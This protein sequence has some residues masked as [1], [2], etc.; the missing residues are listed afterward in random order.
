MMSFFM[1][2][3][4]GGVAVSI[5]HFVIALRHRNTRGALP[6]ALLALSIG[7]YSLG[8]FFEL[9]SSTVDKVFWDNTQFLPTD[10]VATSIFL[11]VIELTVMHVSRWMLVLLALEPLANLFIVWGLPHSYLVR[12]NVQF[13]TIHGESF[14]TYSY[15]PWMWGTIAYLYILLFIATVL[16]G[17]RSLTGGRLERHQARMIFW[18][19]LIPWVGTILTITGNVP[20]IISGLDITPITF[21]ATNIFLALALFRF[22]LLSLVPA[23]R[24]NVL[25]VMD[26]GLIVTSTENFTLLDWNPAAKRLLHPFWHGSW[27]IGVSLIDSFPDLAA[28]KN[29]ATL[30]SDGHSGSEHALFVR[31]T[32]I[33]DD[34]GVSRCKVFIIEDVTEVIQLQHRLEIARNQ[35]EQASITRS[36]FFA[37][38]SHEIR[39]PMGAVISLTDHLAELDLP[40]EANHLLQLLQTQ[41]TALNR[42]LEDI[43]ELSKIE[44]GRIAIKEHRFDLIEILQNLGETFRLIASDRPVK[45]RVDLGAGLPRYV[46]GDQVRLAQVLVNLLTN[47]IK[48]TASGE[49]L[50]HADCSSYE[51]ESGITSPVLVN[52]IVEDSGHGIPEEMLE[53]IFQP[54]E[55]VTEATE[56][57]GGTGLGLAIS[58]QLVELMGGRIYALNRPDKRGARLCFSLLFP[59]AE[60]EV[61]LESRLKISR[62]PSPANL[63]IVDDDPVHRTL[64]E[65][66]L[67][68]SGA[69]CDFAEDGLQAISMFSSVSYDMVLLDIQM[70]RMNGYDVSLNM[71]N[72]E[73]ERSI[74][75]TP[76][77]A[78]TAFSMESE[79]E[80]E[81]LQQAGMDGFLLKPLNREILYNTIMQWA[82]KIPA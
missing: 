67:R 30:E 20:Y 52:F 43:L 53:L 8:Y 21:T 51:A 5:V 25:E 47:A 72:L 18:G 14:L 48:F 11:L 60:E 34:R 36:R 71:R 46:M 61:T 33:E 6:F 37:N 16:I 56:G 54:F 10:L 23:A 9:R 77:I 63:L 13:V 82:F 49:V 64:L 80:K 35:A 22:R 4:F 81:Q 41:G 78:L 75:R 24:A 74:A 39:N 69:H 19:M 70:P 59:L 73:K 26:T 62:F 44:E 31:S 7:A 28:V 66:L 79:E 50:L 57:L 65:V 2:L 29:T 17:R 55:Q 27:A 38:I 15:G 12:S 1:L 40:G 3:A 32:Q 45:L 76:I 58:R 68:H 42:M